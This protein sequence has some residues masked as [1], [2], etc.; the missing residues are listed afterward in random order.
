LTSTNRP[1]FN[2]ANLHNEQPLQFEI[3]A[4]NQIGPSEKVV[5]GNVKVNSP[6]KQTSKNN[7]ECK[8][9]KIGHFYVV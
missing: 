2:L 4:W 1:E 3:Y 7:G 6:A 8:N 9:A 5:I